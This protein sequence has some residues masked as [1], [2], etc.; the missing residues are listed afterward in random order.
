MESWREKLDKEIE[1]MF[2]IKIPVDEPVYPLNI[3]CRILEMH[4]WTVNEVVK[5]HIIHP[6][7]KGKRKKLF[8]YKDIKCLRYVKYL[9][10][11]RGVNIQGVKVIFEIR[12]E[13]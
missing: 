3:V 5:L 10:E 9:I 1:E 12:E 13:E 6:K 2:D 8:S 7:K 4:T 11:E